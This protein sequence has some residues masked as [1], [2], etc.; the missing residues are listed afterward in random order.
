MTREEAIRKMEFCKNAY[1]KLIDEEVDNGTFVGAG[2]NGVWKADT[3][4]TKAYSDMVDACDMAIK[5]LEQE[6][7]ED[8]ISRQA[9][10]EA[11]EDDNRNGLY[12]CF[13]S[14]ND[15]QCFKDVIRKLPPVNPQ[16]PILDKIKAEIK[17]LPYQRIFGKVSSYSLLDAVIEIIDKYKVQEGKA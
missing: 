16:D 3:P 12:S 14:D 1:Q 5:A 10:I 9:V 4:L 6:P 11:I 17:Q 13:A 2:V 7:C 15:A 8:A